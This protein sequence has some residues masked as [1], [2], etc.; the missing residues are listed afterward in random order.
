MTVKNW[1]SC[2]S[3]N[4]QRFYATQ[5]II[6]AYSQL[7]RDYQDRRG[8]AFRKEV[9]TAEE[10]HGIFGAKIPTPTATQFIRIVQGRRVAGTL[11]DP[12][13]YASTA[14]A[15][16]P[17]YQKIL[18]WL[19]KHVPVDEDQN[20]GLRAEAE[21]MQM[22]PETWKNYDPT[23]LYVPNSAP[24]DKD[25]GPYG[26]GLF[27]KMRQER[28]QR[29]QAAKLEKKRLQEA[30]AAEQ[31]KTA[32]RLGLPAVRESPTALDA[33]R[34]MSARLQYYRE[35]A[36]IVPNSIP[37]MTMWQRIGPSMVFSML[38]LVSCAALAYLYSPWPRASRLF[39]EL[40]PS[41]AT[42][43]SLILANFV[44]F[45]AWRF[46]PA[47]RVLNKYFLSVTAYPFVLSMLGA[48]FSHQ[49]FVHLVVTTLPLFFVGTLLHEDVGRGNFLA[50]Y[51]ASGVMGSLTSLIV[52]TVT[53]N[54]LKSS[55]GASGALYGVVAA[56]LWLHLWEQLRPYN[57]L[58]PD[59][60]GLPVSA[61]FAALLLY[62]AH[63]AWRT[64]RKPLLAVDVWSHLGGYMTGIATAQ[65]V[66][67]HTRHQLRMNQPVDAL[68]KTNSH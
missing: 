17:H 6:V 32:E 1:T 29:R 54:I 39:P 16:L 65:A 35:R 25:F 64:G 62:E 46:P 55:L 9:L 18:G 21:L 23:G 60:P 12:D 5:R 34:P 37:E 66:T 38:V 67:W 33:K 36:V 44:V 59:W 24:Q 47:Y 19:R 42:I 58:P 4:Q 15:L 13:I 43:S 50:I 31:S 48:V 52:S 20:A 49:N 40:P 2:A 28:I 63:L 11:D 56:Y 14:P 57:F 10:I 30:Q 3:T 68:A 7:P 51:L 8:L 45:C 61:V 27:D 41:A 53:G 22:D 26:E